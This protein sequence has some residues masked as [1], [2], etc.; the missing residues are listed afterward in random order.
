MRALVVLAI[1]LAVVLSGCD[2]IAAVR[3]N[4]AEDA[5]RAVYGDLEDAAFGDAVA[6]VRASDGAPLAADR[7]AEI[8]RAWTDS[9]AD[10]P[11]T[12]A[13]VAFTGRSKLAGAD[14]ARIR[15]GDAVRLTFELTGTSATSCIGVPATG[16]ALVM[17]RIDGRW[18]VVEGPD[19]DRALLPHC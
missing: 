5:V 18:Y 2:A 11:F 16:L 4:S 17:T 1:S 19:F 7:Q 6:L 12:V 14:A 13:D 15:G 8:L 10:A 3:Q 9:F